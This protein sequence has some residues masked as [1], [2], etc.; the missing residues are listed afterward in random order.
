M[1]A[2]ATATITPLMREPQ[3]A[4]PDDLERAGARV[5]A[6]EEAVPRSGPRAAVFEAGRLHGTRRRVLRFFSGHRRYPCS[7]ACRGGAAFACDL[8]HRSEAVQRR[9][10]QSRRLRGQVHQRPRHQEHHDD[11]EDRGQAQREREAL[12]LADGQKVEHRGRQEA[13]RVAGQ[14]RLAGTGPASRDRRAERTPLADLVLD[15]FEEHHERVGGGADTDD[16][17]RD[18][19]QVERVA[20]VSAEQH[21]DRV[22]HRA[23]GDQRQRRQQT[24]HPVVEQ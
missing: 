24:Q 8:L 11:V 22:N 6:D 3:L 1:L 18:A 10:G 14:D 2:I 23:G 13:D 12:H 16:Q 9:L 17:T 7:V 21:E 15:A 4:P 20:D 5:E 19:C